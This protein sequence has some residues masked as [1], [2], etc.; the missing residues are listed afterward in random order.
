MDIIDEAQRAE[1]LE[2][3]AALGARAVR[4]M[5]ETMRVTREICEDCGVTIPEAR[6]RAVPGCIRCVACQTQADLDDF[7][8]GYPL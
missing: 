3:R 8:R 7:E 2:I 4:R 6:R 5:A 1:A